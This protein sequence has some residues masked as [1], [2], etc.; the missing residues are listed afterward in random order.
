MKRPLSMTAYG[1]GEAEAESVRWAAEVRSV[2]HR[3]CDIRIKISRKYAALEERIKKLVMQH[4]SRGHIDV[5]IDPLGAGALSPAL[6]PNLAL[7]SEYFRCLTEIQQHLGL[8]TQPELRTI[9]E[10]RDVIVITEKEEDLEAIWVPIRDA[11][12]LALTNAL[13][14]RVREGASLKDDLAARLSS[15]TSAIRDIEN[16][17]P[18]IVAKRE[19]SLQERLDNL[20][21]GVDI[22]PI[23]LTQEI[24]IM[25]DKSDVTEELVRLNSHIRQFSHYLTSDEP[26]GRKLDFLLQEF[27]REVNTLT[28]KIADDSIAHQAVEL[29][30]EIEKMREQIQNIE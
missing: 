10:Y 25:A 12:E 16:A 23:R 5:N 29:K 30:S 21:N 24:A 18:S 9:A 22:D 27:F 19:K 7:A 20:L 13:Q 2:N 14:M 1:R 17:V 6:S 15:F 4:Y 11:V 26:S 3:Y 8:A 28:T